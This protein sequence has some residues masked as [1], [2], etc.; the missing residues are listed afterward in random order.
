[1]DCCH[2]CNLD[3]V[4]A[5]WAHLGFPAF[6]FTEPEL[7]DRAYRGRSADFAMRLGWQRQRR[8]GL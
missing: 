3:A 6:S 2:H 7:I 4:S 8:M 1:M 5:Y